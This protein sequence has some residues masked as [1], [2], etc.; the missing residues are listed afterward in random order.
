VGAG[1]RVH[2]TIIWPIACTKTSAQAVLP[3][4][5]DSGAM[6]SNPVL[7]NRPGA[8]VCYGEQTDLLGKPMA[9]SDACCLMNCRFVVSGACPCKFFRFAAQKQWHYSGTTVAP[10]LHGRRLKNSGWQIPSRAI[11]IKA[12]RMV[13]QLFQCRSESNTILAMFYST[14]YHAIKL[15]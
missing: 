7:L 8:M 4:A 15:V 13:L 6:R 5:V 2:L 10:Q 11:R 12:R 14:C 9:V 3:I 1:C